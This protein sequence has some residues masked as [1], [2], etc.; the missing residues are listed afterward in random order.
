MKRKDE[1]NNDC[2]SYKMLILMKRKE[3][4]KI[5]PFSCGLDG[6]KSIDS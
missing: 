5:I 2:P 1:T 3:T 6:Q 4:M